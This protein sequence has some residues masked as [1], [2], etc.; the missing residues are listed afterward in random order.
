MG[1]KIVDLTGQSFG[2]LTVISRYIGDDSKYTHDCH[3][4]CM[5]SCGKEHV[6]KSTHLKSGTV[7]SCGC[8]NKETASRMGT[9]RKENLRG[10]RFGRLVV[11][12]Y[13]GHSV[14]SRPRN[15]W[16]CICDCGNETTV[17]AQSLKGGLTKS[18]G[19]YLREATKQR[20]TTHGQSKTKAYGA[21]RT[22]KY[23]E[24]K[25]M[26]DVVWTLE[27]EDYLRQTQHTCAIC[28]KTEQESN[29]RLE[30]DHVNPL[31]RG[32]GLAPGNA[33]ILCGECNA[34]KKDKLLTE[35]S[36][37]VA[38]RLLTKAWEFEFLWGYYCS[39]GKNFYEEPRD[40]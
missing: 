10:K 36:W 33:A 32:R 31:S 11:I 34:R 7:K 1:R 17:M 25:R 2:R 22:R 39:T 4:M 38:Y 18:C 28:G 8:L 14:G 6:V 40:E 5:C 3:W 26:F 20:M 37:D 15:L 27:M 9:K 24:Q 30:V 29:K 35:L 19:C 13:A 23:R 16:K 21:F 12:D